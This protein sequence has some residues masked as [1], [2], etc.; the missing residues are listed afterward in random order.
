MRPI[1][2]TLCLLCRMQIYIFFFILIEPLL[3]QSFIKFYTE[4]F[5][6]Q[7][8]ELIGTL[9]HWYLY[10]VEINLLPRIWNI[11]TRL[12]KKT[13]VD[14]T[15]GKLIIWEEQGNTKHSIQEVSI[16]NLPF[17]LIFQGREDGG[18]HIQYVP[19]SNMFS[20]SSHI[21]IY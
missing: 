6:S 16:I 14:L 5:F 17:L 21:F 18:I 15:P 19:N 9:I 4:I 13:E 10:W 11:L 3:Q 1:Y 8:T 7:F 20:L 12:N 2:I